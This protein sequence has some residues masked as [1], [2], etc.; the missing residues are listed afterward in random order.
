M[1]WGVAAAA[2]VTVIGGAMSSS[3]AAKKAK[4]GQQ[5]AAAERRRQFDLTQKQ[6]APYREAGAKGLKSYEDLLGDRQTY[7]DKIQSNIPD[8]YQNDSVIPDAF[9][10]Q[11][12]DYFGKIDNN[13]QQDFQFGRQQ[14][15]QYKDP[16]YDFRMEEGQR[17]LERSNARGGKRNSGYNTRSLMELGQNLGSQEFGAARDRAFQDYQTGVDRE[18][19]RY[20]RSAQDYGRRTGREGELY[21][22]G[23]QQRLDETLRENAQYG[24]NVD[25]YNRSRSTEQQ[26]YGRSV[27]EYNRTYTDPM[28]RYS[29]LA[30]MGQNTVVN[31][32]SQRQDMANANAAGMAQSGR[33]DAAAEIA[34]GDAYA[35][36]IG[37]MGGAYQD[38]NKAQNAQTGS[39]VK[40]WGSV[41]G[42]ADMPAY[43]RR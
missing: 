26:Q 22:R 25:D 11:A 28:N 21:G 33:T 36:A 7:E 18:S 27:D 30:T 37:A 15:D 9:S 4:K 2:A 34:K 5:E 31:A 41:P 12:G 19:Q 29:G 20:G 14:F 43:I 23:R 35:G 24:R 8:A 38:W 42:D 10:Q 40:D 39:R 6:Q 1:P 32:G 17:A 13:V 3:S 16:G